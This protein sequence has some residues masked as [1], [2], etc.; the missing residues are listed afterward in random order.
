[1][2]RDIIKY[3]L[4]LILAIIGSYIIFYNTEEEKKPSDDASIPRE[5]VFKTI[6]LYDDATLSRSQ[7]VTINNNTYRITYNIDSIDLNDKTIFTTHETILKQVVL[8]DN[9]LFVLTNNGEE[10]SLYIF[11][12]NGEIEEVYRTVTIDG[13]VM[14]LGKMN[15]WESF[16][17]S[18]FFEIDNDI[19]KIFY[20]SLD[21]S[22]KV[23]IFDSVYTLDFTTC[24]N[25]K[26]GYPNA[27]IGSEYHYIYK[28]RRNDLKVKNLFK[29]M[30]CNG[31][32]S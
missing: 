18:D 28:E 11:N 15:S 20:T 7:K 9:L 31:L 21:S 22:S 12:N 19:V 27:L 5:E 6:D 1:M 26:K 17:P 32:I 16:K 2:K 30:D 8:F 25:L 4:L 14:H 10:K 24:N 13:V 29:D 3:C 23:K